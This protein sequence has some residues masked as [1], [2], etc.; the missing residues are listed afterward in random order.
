MKTVLDGVRVVDF[1][2]YLAGPMLGMMLADYGAEVIRVDP[3][4]GPLWDD[5]ANAILHRG[6]RSIILDLKDDADA[7]IARKL[8]ASSDIVIENFAPGVMDRLGLSAHEM[9]E[10]HSGLIWC[11]MPGFAADDPR[12]DLPA[13]EGVICAAAG[14]YNPS[15]FNTVG[16]PVFSALPLASFFGAIVASHGVAAALFHRERT[17]EGQHIEIPLFEAAFQAIACYGENPF[18]TG[19]GP[20]HELIGELVHPAVLRKYRGKDGRLIG[21]SPPVRPWIKLQEQLIPKDLLAKRDPES[22]AKVIAVL[23]ET[24]RSRTALEWE[25]HFQTELGVCAAAVQTAEDWLADEHARATKCVIEVEDPVLGD[26]WQAGFAVTMDQTPPRVRHPR[27]PLD[28]DGP[29]L[30]VELGKGEVRKPSASGKESFANALEGI[31]VADISMLLAGPT[32]ARVLANYGADVIK[33]SNPR[34]VSANVDPLSDDVAALLGHYT[35]NEGKRA[36]MI[37]VKTPSGKRIVDRLIDTADV[38]HQNFTPGVAERLGFGEADVR[39]RRPDVIYSSLNM[40]AHGG[41]RYAFRGHEELGQFVSGLAARLG[42]DGDPVRSPVLV[43]DHATGHLSAFGIILALY[44]RERTGEGQHVRAALSQTSTIAQLPFMLQYK[45]K[46]WDEPTGI[47][48]KGWGPLNRI[49][50]TAM[51]H[52]YLAALGPDVVR[53]LSQ[54]DGLEGI[55][56]VP[57]DQLARELEQ[58]FKLRA[59]TNWAGLL[60]MAG[61]GAHAYVPMHD[62]MEQPFSRQRGLSVVSHHPGLGAMRTVGVSGRFSRTQPRIHRSVPAPGLDIES[63]LNDLG[64]ETSVEELLD[65]GA[66]AL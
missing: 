51:G 6:K 35:V 46:V 10:K 13:W 28:N 34:S 11:S 27:V 32:A 2:Q 57:A 50:E 63:V 16:D 31:R 65:E 44:H 41:F 56:S 38:V 53:K 48:A 33:V 1:G 15:M 24:Y 64:I 3:P 58:R 5:P 23:E 9:V 4:G 47:D 30:R 8:V 62:V 54:V 39:R 20:L 21:M 66:I 59:A 61:L 12:C 22:I 40:H 7:A 17:G 36:T 19:A 25:I 42:G 18:N 29:A 26:T 60:A 49:Y 43:N 14:L 37:D 45:G 55:D 52:L